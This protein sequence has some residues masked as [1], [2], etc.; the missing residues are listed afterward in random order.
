MPKPTEGKRK[1]FHIILIAVLGLIVYSNILNAPFYF[2]DRPFITN[3]PLIKDFGFFME[4]SKA[5]GFTLRED[6]RRYFKT[7][8][9][10]FLSLW[11]N[12]R[13]GELDVRGYHAINI[14]I[15]IANALIVYIIVSLSFRTPFLNR[16]R[17]K[18]YSH[19]I[20][21]FSGLFFVSHPLQTEA[22]T[23]ILQ[24]LVVL[25]AMFY[26]FSTATYIGSRLSS[27]RL[28]RYGLY[29][30][31]LISAFLGMKTKENTF[32]LPIAITIYEFIFFKDNIRKRGLLLFPFL[33][34]MLII[35]FAYFNMNSGFVN[36][37]MESTTV[38]PG[39]SRTN[40]LF[41]QFS[42][43]VSYMRL[44]LFPV[45]QSV[46]HNHALFYSFFEPQV[47]F[48][49]ILLLS[50]FGF[51]IYMLRHSRKEFAG[52]LL[53]FGIFW[54]IVTLSVESS[55]MPIGEIMVEY[56]IYLPSTGFFIVV[57]VLFYSL[58][59][60]AKKTWPF[61]GKAFAP[62]LLLTVVVMSGAAYA[63]NTV[64][65]SEISLWEDV[66][67]KFPQNSRAHNN[68]GAAYFVA[69][70]TD[71]AIKHYST[72]VILRSDFAMAHN[73]LGLAYKTKG[74]TDKAIEHYLTALKLKPDYVEVHKKIGFLYDE[75]GLIG[76][77]VEHFNKV[78][79]FRP[80]DAEAHNVLASFH[81]RRGQINTAVEHLQEA[82]RLKP[83]FADAHNNIALL[84]GFKGQTDKTVEHLRQALRIKPDFADAHFNLGF[85]YLEKGLVDNARME[86][87]AALKIKPDHLKAREYL[88]KITP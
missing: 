65:K 59:D 9:V 61:F 1:G 41:T 68:L 60:Y 45:D 53:T 78:L 82:I 3:N 5:D 6:V 77:A 50:I 37:I 49:F 39:M 63:R 21:L 36:A 55:F 64:W 23:Y 4:P 56:R 24:R 32:T 72:A 22:V 80:D 10:G 62:L 46:D 87:E 51:G 35:P 57:V 13:L 85:V 16:S 29:A 25:S 42:V 74:L 73:N 38:A 48:S 8:Y 83:D 31:A 43:V 30:L 81:I 34:T 44:L 27:R 67:E 70:L 12:Y 54:F 33:L 26:L 84:Y 47:F 17:L 52:R 86:F 69:G 20:A 15:H 79:T 58:F 76:K 88:E 14:A 66:V 2:D 18:K 71:K 75:L 28:S 7:R 19:H 11:V 40:Y